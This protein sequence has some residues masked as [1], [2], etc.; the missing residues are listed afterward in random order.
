MYPSDVVFGGANGARLG[1]AS[2]VVVVVVEVVVVVVEAVVVVA[3]VEVLVSVVVVV[4]VVVD[5]G[6]SQNSRRP[7]ALLLGK[8]FSNLVGSSI[9]DAGPKAHNTS[10][11][12]R[13]I[14]PSPSLSTACLFL[15]HA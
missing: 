11:D 3:V 2:F 8:C 15:V 13:L 10:T 14:V 5:G 12:P 7:A 4:T 9:F 1:S 6:A